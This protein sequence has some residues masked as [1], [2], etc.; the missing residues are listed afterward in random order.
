MI[1]ISALVVAIQMIAAFCK[2]LKYERKIFLVTNGHG[3]MDAADVDHIV[4]KLVEDKI[5]LTVL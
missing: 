1:A 4:G 2:Q 5:E 3:A